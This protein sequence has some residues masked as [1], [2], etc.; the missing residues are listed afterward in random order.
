MYFLFKEEVQAAVQELLK[1]K[2]EY[3]KLNNNNNNIELTEEEIT[4]C[5]QY[6]IYM[7]DVGY[8]IPNA[9]VILGHIDEPMDEGVVVELTW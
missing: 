3:K 5:I 2:E 7:L 9:H 6:L 1:L 4:T 8:F